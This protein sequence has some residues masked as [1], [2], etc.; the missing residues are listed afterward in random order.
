MTLVSQLDSAAA[1]DFHRGFVELCEGYRDGNRIRA[2][3]RY[4][5]TLGTRR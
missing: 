2:P 4:L 3:R 1:E 5:L